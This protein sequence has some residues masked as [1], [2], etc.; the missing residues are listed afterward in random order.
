MLSLLFAATLALA[1]PSAA[2]P[3]L[4][5]PVPLTAAVTSNLDGALA[6]LAGSKPGQAPGLEAAI[7]ENGRLVYSRGFGQAKPDTR[8]HL[9]SISKMFTAVAVM[10]LV[11]AHRIALDAKVSTYLP[12][13]PHA[14][15]ITV[16]ELLQHTAGLWN[17]GDEAVASGATAK[18]TTPAAIL[19]LVASHPL[20]A[21]PGT[22][23]AYSNSG[24]VVLGLI[25]ERVTGKPLADV[26]RQ[27]I[28]APAGMRETT[29]G[30]APA[31]VPVAIGY[32]SGPG[33]AAPVDDLSW[34]YACGDLVSTAADL[35]RFDIALMNGTLVSPAT[36]AQM[37]SDTTTIAPAQRQGLGVMVV[38]AIGTTLV[39]HH[40][41]LPGFATEDEMIP[42]DG[43][44]MI[45]L[46]N[47]G[48]FITASANH[49]I[50]RVL[51]PS[52]GI[53]APT[54]GIEDP[55]TTAKFR[56][57]LSA[58]LDGTV[59]VTQ[60]ADA[61]RAVFTPA[62]I[63]QTAQQLKPLGTIVSITYLGSSGPSTTYRVVFSSGQTLVWRFVLAP[64]GKILG[65]SA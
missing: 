27:K 1:S 15:E 55:A 10:Q 13:A 62:L 30:L 2:S 29:I 5:P 32:R 22:T 12:T 36:F 11:E 28:L 6:A 17:Y 52:L 9:A 40:G 42:G 19:A 58:L 60:Y 43:F 59:D 64:D 51:F 14:N 31:N 54:A 47:A 4:P 8:V 33:P 34:F 25:V 7:V 61:A 23:Y 63:A 57:A 44:A 50:V 35:A 46:S 48:D 26:I 38:D 39:G 21:T 16:R 18:P 37:R 49:E 41:G 20:T 3:T 24:Y 53:P 65:I 56:A 45:V